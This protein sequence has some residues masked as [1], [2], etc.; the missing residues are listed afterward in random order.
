[1]NTFVKSLFFRI[2]FPHF[3]V[4][5]IGDLSNQRSNIEENNDDSIYYE[6]KLQ[7]NKIMVF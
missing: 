3:Y 4:K 2:E 6:L 7:I 5:D 1:M